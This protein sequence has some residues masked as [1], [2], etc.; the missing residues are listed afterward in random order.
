MRKETRG[1]ILAILA[2][3][4]SGVSI[5]L[6]KLFLVKLDPFVFTAIRAVAIGIVFLVICL[7][8]SR[9]KIT[10]F[11]KVPWKYLIAIAVIGGAA[12]FLLFFVGLTMTTA[13]RAAFLQKSMPIYV[14]I[15]AFIFLKEKITKKM[16][17]ALLVMFAGVLLIYFSQV[18]PSQF[19]ANPSMGDLLILAATV[20]W[21]LELVISKKAMSMG[22]SNFVVSFARMFLGGIILL[23]IV[24]LLG[25][26]DLL[27]TLT[28]IQWRNIAISTVLLLGY[29][30]FLYRSLLYISASKSSILLLLAPFISVIGGVLVFS[31]PLPPLQ[32]AGS[33]AIL[34]GA[35][36]LSG[37]KIGR[38]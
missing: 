1:I 28:A 2:A 13:S 21:A 8:Q 12:A 15:F 17:I 33:A 3:V 35:Y 36:F 20:L 23:G 30:L 38:K 29:V 19:W 34:V 14:I 6:N 7:W 5:P 10:K 4:I 31:D 22:E 16:G 26:V 37:V 24:I 11:K 18:T 32:I 27:L 9:G 25:K